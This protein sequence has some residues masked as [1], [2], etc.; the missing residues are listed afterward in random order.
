MLVEPDELVVRDGIL[1]LDG[2]CG[3]LD[4][5]L[6]LAVERADKPV[7]LDDA[8]SVVSFVDLLAGEADDGAAAEDPEEFRSV[9]A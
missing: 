3:D 7:S 5:R 8:V 1:V 9:E 4:G 2:L 6:V